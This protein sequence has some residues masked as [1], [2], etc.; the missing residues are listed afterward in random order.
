MLSFEVSQEVIAKT[1]AKAATI[2]HFYV[3]KNSVYS[4]A[5]S[6]VPFEIEILNEGGA[7]DLAT[8][9]FTAPVP[10]IYHFEFSG[11][12]S[13]RSLSIHLQV[14][15]AWIGRGYTDSGILGNYDTVSLSSSL[16]LKAGDRVD[17]YKLGNGELY[18]DG[19]HSTHF[20]GWLVE[21]GI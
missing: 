9:R 18:D 6:V 17:L 8:G 15:G 2:V 19:G 16:R 1:N 11:I 10:G 5:D 4:T 7:M 12:T 21:E 20:T 14:N 3:Q 13:S